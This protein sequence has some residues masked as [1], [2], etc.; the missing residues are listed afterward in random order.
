MGLMEMVESRRQH[1]E[2]I[3]ADAERVIE[4]MEDFGEGNG[5]DAAFLRYHYMMGMS[6]EDACAKAGYSRSYYKE[7]NSLALVHASYAV[8]RLGL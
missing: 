2:R 5:G 6:Q 7:K 4:N 1:Y 3:M 8:M